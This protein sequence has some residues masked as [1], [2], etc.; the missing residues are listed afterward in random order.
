MEILKKVL[1]HLIVFCVNS[2]ILLMILGLMGLHKALTSNV[3]PSDMGIDAYSMFSISVV[4]LCGSGV[5]W[6][7]RLIT[8]R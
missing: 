6:L 4:L 1:S 7:L 5:F 8:N 3:S 2:A